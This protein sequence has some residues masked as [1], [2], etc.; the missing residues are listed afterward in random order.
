M[1]ITSGANATDVKRIR[2]TMAAY[3]TRVHCLKIA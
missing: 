3:P 1:R 2:R